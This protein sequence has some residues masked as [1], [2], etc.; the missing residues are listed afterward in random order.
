MHHAPLS[1]RL[2]SGL[3]TLVLASGS[4]ARAQQEGAQ[5]PP[6]SGAGTTAIVTGTVI[7]AQDSQPLLG[8][9]VIIKGT[10]HWGL[11]NQRGRFRLAGLPPGDVTIEFRPA[12]RAPLTYPLT[13][14][15]GKTTNLAVTVDTRTVALPEVVVEGADRPA[16]KMDEFFRHKNSGRGGYFITR[17]DIERKQPRVMS[18]MLRSVPGLRVDC[19]FGTCQV[20]TFEEARRIAGGCPIQYFLDGTPFSGDIDELTPDQVEGIEV[21]RGSSTIPPDYNT[22]TAMCGV[23]A[24]WSRVPGR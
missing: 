6:S 7:S 8:V 3:L 19:S 13:L 20:Q 15:P 2:L 1:F 14:Q 11:T 16:A 12:N 23:I 4:V 22:G 9:Q 10:H 21:Y 24:V 17:N 5:A 18:D